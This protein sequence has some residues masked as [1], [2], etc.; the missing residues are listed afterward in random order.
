MKLIVAVFGIAVLL[1][2]AWAALWILGTRRK[3]LIR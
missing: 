1:V 2:L 3:K